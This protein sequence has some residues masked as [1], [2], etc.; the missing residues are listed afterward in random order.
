MR[1]AG[2]L[3]PIASL[4]SSYGVGDFGKE[5]YDFIDLLKENKVK[6]WQILPLNPLGYGNSPYQNL[7]SY[8]IDECYLSLDWLYE[9]KW[10]RKPKSFH[11]HAKKIDYEACRAFKRPYIEEAYLQFKKNASYRRFCQQD[12][13]DDFCIFIVL[14]RKN[15]YRCWTEWP[16]EDKNVLLHPSESLKAYSKEIEIE[17][18]IQYVL[19]QQWISLKR[20]AHKAHVMILG[21]IPFYVGLDSADVFASP[22]NFLLDEQGHPS[23]IAGVPPD[24]FSP[25]GQ[26]WGNPIYDWDFMV[27][28][29]FNFWLHRLS[30]VSKMFDFI[31]IDHFRAFDTF[32]KIPSSCETAIEGEW[33]EAPGYLFFDTLFE[34]Y[35]NLKIVA[36]DLGL[37]RDEVYQ[38]RDYYQFPG[39][40][41][42]QFN[43]N[44]DHPELFPN[45]KNM[46]VYTGTHDN[47]SLKS[48]Y[49]NKNRHD[50]KKMSSYLKSTGD[51]SLSIYQKILVFV[52]ENKAE[53]SIIS[54]IDLL[55]YDDRCR[56]NTPG[57]VGE[58][59]WC[60][61][62]SSYQD[63]KKKLPFLKEW[64]IKTKRA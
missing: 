53:I 11:K 16:I 7:S 56:L 5:S 12:W 22:Q 41:V 48:W 14:R 30:Y 39:M 9:K 57:T 21:D 36:E 4:P 19:Y 63:V 32:W 47:E 31:R 38:L 23:F 17:K 40:N 60:W 51:L 62:L 25:T 2:I 52:L 6:V 43:F 26:R 24:Y 33:I 18:F 37:L 64:I 20:Y 8:A 27:K 34:K 61:R 1:K 45:Q 13:L 28:D 55:E 35:P 58:P 50:Q 59:N 49:K 46:I 54:M 15:E 3:M 29:H 42:F 44:V 10:I